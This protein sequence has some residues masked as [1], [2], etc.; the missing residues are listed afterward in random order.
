MLAALAILFDGFDNQLI[1]FAI[2][3]LVREWSVSRSA[4]WSVV[5]AGLLGMVIGGALAG[6]VGDRLGRQRALIVS[7]FVFGLGTA[8]A[9]FAQGLAMLGIFRLLAGAG[10]GGAIP[11]ASVLTAEFTPTSRRA[12]AITLT[13]V[14]VPLG[15]MVAG[16]V[17][18]RVLPVEGWRTLFRIG[19]IVPL[20]YAA[21]L[22]FVLPESPRFLVFRPKRWHELTTLLSRMGIAVE[23]GSEFIEESD[24]KPGSKSPV[25]VLFRTPHIR[26]TAG[27]WISFFSCLSAV[28]LVFNWLPALLTAEGL[29][30]AQASSGLSAY[31]F[32]GVLGPVVCALLVTKTGSRI[33]MLPAALFAAASALIVLAVPTSNPYLMIFTLGVHGFFVNGVQTTMYALPAHIYQTAVRATG[34]GWA[35]SI[36]RVGAVL[37]AF[38]G[39]KAVQTG[40]SGYFEILCAALLLTFVGLAIIQRHIPSRAGDRHAIRVRA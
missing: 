9:S 3:S 21:L 2:P 6:T 18:A 15:G 34:V 29:S 25:K 33:T 40:R 23:N 20:L 39:A 31:N 35:A 37:S 16:L 30:L 22:I 5:A 24:P 27:L 8:A 1:G 19:G 10:I 38:I 26:N 4:F 17:A 14:C 7:M 28:Y 13:I 11:N 12:L 36:G 32:G